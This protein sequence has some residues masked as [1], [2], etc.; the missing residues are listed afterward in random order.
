VTLP[1][2]IHVEFDGVEAGAGGDVEG[3]GAGGAEDAVGGALGDVNHAEGFAFFVEDVDAFGG[4]VE[5]AKGIAGEA[6]AALGLS[7]VEGGEFAAVGD[8]AIGLDGVGP[9]AVAAVVHDVERGLVIGDEHAIGA[10]EVADNADDVGRF[11]AVFVRR[12]VIDAFD[13]EGHF[14]GLA[15]VAGVGEV[16]AAFAVDVEVVGG[17]VGFAVEGFGQGGDGAAAGLLTGDAAGAA[18]TGEQ[19]AGGGEHEAVGFAGVF[20]VEGDLLGFGIE[21]VDAFVGD[22]AEG[23]AAIRGEGWAFGEFETFGDFDDFDFF[24][25]DALRWGDGGEFG[26]AVGGVFLKADVP[27]A[28]FEADEGIRH[29]VDLEG[30]ETFRGEVVFEVGSGDAVEEGAEAAADGFDA[31]EVP[32][33]GFEGEA[34]AVVVGE[35]VQPAAAAFI[36]NAGGPAAVAGIDLALVAVDLAVFVVGEAL[37]AEL[38]AGVEVGIDL[39]FE[40]EDEVA[41]VFVGEEEGVRGLGDGDA[42]DLAVFDAVFGFAAALGPA[43]EVLAVEER[44]PVGGGGR[45]GGEG[46]EGEEEERAHGG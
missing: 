39:E 35:V 7:G 34:G 30:D 6:V 10:D 37:A 17:V 22:V 40:L 27:P 26:G 3:L 2:P 41:V 32:V 25:Q 5:V 42:D 20:A 14:L 29:A 11:A 36:I 16:E 1:P 38:D 24:R 18:F 23:D 45:E 13:A 19:G 12:G 21:E 8:F 4:D 15:A 44:G 46:G 28:D 9:E 31:H 43:V 33:A